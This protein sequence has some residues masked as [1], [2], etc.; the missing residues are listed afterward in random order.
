MAHTKSLCIS[1]ANSNAS[2]TYDRGLI[3]IDNLMVAYGTLVFVQ[4]WLST[5]TSTLIINFV[6]D[7][8]VIE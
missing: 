1:T 3:T 2:P 5:F 4:D 7:G 6:K 8:L